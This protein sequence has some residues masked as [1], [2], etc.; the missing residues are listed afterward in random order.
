MD[1][2][3]SNVVARRAID[4]ISKCYGETETPKYMKAFILQEITESMCLI[5]VLRDEV[6]I[7]K[8]A[9]GQVNA[10]I[11]EIEAIDDPFEY[12]D[13]FGCLKDSKKIS[14]G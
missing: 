11:A 14:I 4:E 2:R 7:E 6:D 1:S 8:I 3:S 10:M 13:S 9:L 12:A 5:K